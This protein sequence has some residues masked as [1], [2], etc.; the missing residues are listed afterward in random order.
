M[1]DPSIYLHLGA[2]KTASTML[3][4]AMR[5]NESCLADHKLTCLSVHSTTFELYKPLRTALL[6][7]VRG[8]VF[9]HYQRRD[10]NVIAS[11]V[12][13]AREK[14][15]AL[16]ESLDTSALL[17]SDENLLGPPPG[18]QFRRP[19]VF[20]SGLYAGI[21]TI[22]SAL[23]AV[24]DGFTTRVRF[25]TRRQSTLIESLYSNSVGNLTYGG[26]IEMFLQS[27]N[28]TQSG[29]TGSSRH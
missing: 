1:N 3:Q 12:R 15:L 6:Q 9:E 23:A 2:H 24:F 21:E 20:V 14:F 25:Y 26:D 16:A 13:E 8:I 11:R 27:L 19:D 7:M 5:A 17:I 28:L 18:V 10:Q 29:L 4:R 22:V